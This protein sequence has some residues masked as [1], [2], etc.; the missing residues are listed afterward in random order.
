MLSSCTGIHAIFW[1]ILHHILPYSFSL[2]FRLLGFTFISSLCISMVERYLLDLRILVNLLKVYKKIAVWRHV[3]TED[4]GLLFI[5]VL[6]RTLG[7]ILGKKPFSLQSLTGSWIWNQDFYLWDRKDKNKNLMIIFKAHRVKC[8]TLL[9][10]GG[11]SKYQVK[12]WLLLNVSIMV[13]Y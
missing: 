12:E 11:Y 7:F 2:M 5:P 9:Q 8:D 4:V 13:K 6:R 1:S 3:L 10:N